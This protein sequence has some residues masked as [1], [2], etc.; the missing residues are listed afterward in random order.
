MTIAP[1]LSRCPTIVHA[2]AGAVAQVPFVTALVCEERRLSY[3]ELGRAVSG[4]ARLLAA[5]GARG[6]RVVVLLPTSIEAVVS[7]LAVLAA[8]A[9]L[10][11]VDP[12][13]SAAVLEQILIEAEPCLIV[14]DATSRAALAELES[15][16]A[17]PHRLVWGSLEL[18][19][20]AWLE[21]E[22]LDLTALEL[23]LPD[24][25]ALLLFTSS[26]TGAP[27]GVEHAH[28]GVALSL[29]QHCTCWPVAS[30]RD[31]FLDV[32]PLFDVWG[33]MYATLV[34]IYA[35]ATRVLVPRFDAERVL[36]AIEQHAISVFAGGPAAIYSALLASARYGST[37]FSSLRHSLSD[38][39][40]LPPEL[41]ETWQR[42]T[43]RPLLTSWSL[44]EAAPLCLSDARVPGKPGSV[45]RAAPLTQVSVVDRG[46]GRDEL[47]PNQPGQVRVRGP[48]L[49]LGY[50]NRPEETSAALREGWLYTSEIGYLDEDG[51]LFL[52]ER[53]VHAPARDD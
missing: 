29:L 7:A 50:R 2:L 23:P 25:L 15:R 24:E 41:F 47:P 6:G 26:T 27:R 43:R 37:D 44:A 48:Q 51:F 11:P 39:A 53:S 35:R 16:R 18:D 9:Q 14:C 5:L 10:T 40:A 31:R 21:D 46:T 36:A 42:G 4:L 22:S 38:G 3:A 12:S 30:G 33:L 8:P 34:P 17:L 28:R 32:A 45:G 1:G 19:V 52:N 20:S 49:M 13:V